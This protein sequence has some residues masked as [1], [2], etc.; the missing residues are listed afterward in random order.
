MSEQTEDKRRSQ[1]VHESM[2]QAYM[3][4]F[5]VSRE[6]AISALQARGLIPSNDEKDD[7]ED[8]GDE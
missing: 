1:K 4:I 3:N 5:A 6:E 8:N 7:Q 2:I